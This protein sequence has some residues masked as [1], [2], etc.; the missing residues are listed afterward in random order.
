MVRRRWVLTVTAAALAA[1]LLAGCDPTSLRHAS[2]AEPDDPPGEIDRP[3]ATVD[4]DVE[5]GPTS[6][7]VHYRLVND[8]DV[9]L[10]VPHRLSTPTGAFDDDAALVYITGAT[11]DEEDVVM[12]SQRVFATPDSDI[13][14]AQAPRVGATV[15]APGDDLDVALEVPLPLQRR[16]PWG[17]D[18]GDGTIE[19]PDPTSGVLFCL[20]VLPAPYAPNYGVERQDGVTSISHGSATNAGQYLFCSDRADLD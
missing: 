2:P 10:L 3:D 18:L 20:G 4:I 1:A 14:L 15:V 9:E 16:S 19:L 12:L 17:D 11:G 13:D 8:G 7:R 6:V 5:P